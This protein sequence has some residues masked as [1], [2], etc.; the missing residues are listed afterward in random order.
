MTADT[1]ALNRAIGSRQAFVLALPTGKLRIEPKPQAATATSF[2]ATVKDPEGR[3]VGEARF[4]SGD[5]LRASIFMR[6]KVRRIEGDGLGNYTVTE[7]DSSRFPDEAPS[8]RRPGALDDPSPIG[9]L[10]EATP[11]ISLLL[12]YEQGVIDK[13]GANNI[14]DF[15]KEMQQELDWTYASGANPV[16]VKGKIVASAKYTGA[17]SANSSVALQRLISNGDAKTARDT[18]KADLVALIATKLD[19][20]C[21]EGSFYNQGSAAD[22]FSVIDLACARENHSLSHEVGH[23]LGADHAR[24][25]D[26]NQDPKAC[27]YGFKAPAIKR[28][29][30][31]AYKCK[32]TEVCDRMSYLSDPDYKDTNVA[33][34]AKCSATDAASNIETVRAKAP[35]VA[36]YR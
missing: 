17:T 20:A 9:A 30:V 8:N 4:L 14:A 25:D 11:E 16:P 27:N 13:L 24:G 6:G 18:E 28:R 3:E 32:G 22:A 29:T 26:K 33:M 36:G 1:A 7:S 2:F 31:M 12:L 34:G 35:K 23:N 15:V 10:D 5:R 21:G 19:N